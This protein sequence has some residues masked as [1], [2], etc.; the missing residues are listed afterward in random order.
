[1]R[2]TQGVNAPAFG[3]AACYQGTDADDFMEWMA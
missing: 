1:M 3:L 2:S